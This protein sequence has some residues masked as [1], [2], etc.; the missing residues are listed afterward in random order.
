[1]QQCRPCLCMLSIKK[2]KNKEKEQRKCSSEC[3]ETNKN[4][5]EPF[6]NAITQK[7][8]PCSSSTPTCI[9][10]P[11]AQLHQFSVWSVQHTPHAPETGHDPQTL[12]FVVTRVPK[13]IFK[14]AIPIRKWLLAPHFL[15]PVI[16]NERYWWGWKC[17][18][19]Y[20]QKSGKKKWMINFIP[21]LLRGIKPAVRST[22]D[23]A[24]MV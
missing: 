13:I 18:V 20:K 19:F 14:T 6:H 22:L 9:Q 4:W 11:R 21:A 10:V 16:G 12:L 3:V 17:L 24:F 23:A 1:M 5:T 15:K 2:I 8:R 7:A